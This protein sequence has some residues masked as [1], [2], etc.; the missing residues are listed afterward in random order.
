MAKLT[1]RS[2]FVFWSPLALTWLMIG[3][4]APFLAAIVARLPNPRPNLAAWGIAVAIAILVEAPVIMI[5]SASTAMATDRVAFVRLRA[6][7]YILC[8]A[9]TFI[10]LAA[11]LSPAMDLLVRRAMTVPDR[12]AALTVHALFILL[13]WPAAIG[14]RRFY[15]G[16]LI[17]DGQ[18]RKVALGT[19][20]RLGS[21]GAT[22]MVLYLGFQIPGAYVGAAA[23]TAGVVMEAL[24][25]RVMA[26]R[27]VR[28]L[29]AVEPVEDPVTYGRIW[30]FYYP[31]ALTSTIY[32]TVQP[33]T[34]FFLGRSRMSLESLAVMPVIGAL[35]FLFRAVGISFMEAAIA[36][37][38]DS[39][40]HNRAI[41]RF[42]VTLAVSA[43]AA[44]GLVAFTPLSGQWFEK[45]S[46]LSRELT[47]FA[48]LPTMILVLIPAASVYFSYQRAV[49][50]KAQRTPPITWS[51]M[52]QVAC[53]VAA[54]FIAVELLDTVGAVAAA[55][56]MVLG[57]VVGNS[58]LL[59]PVARAVSGAGG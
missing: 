6:F 13:P 2:I 7:T 19:V 37:L 25:S 22:A 38:G 18:T 32:L 52:L 16:L 57:S 4:E 58:L 53:T 49:L 43:S 39:F 36:L 54:L 17:R 27:I 50:V 21:M 30:S 23:L 34:S 31:L 5:M 55:G 15:Q 9:I 12:V 46:G 51:T 24:A 42:A 20:I 28:K 59:A 45:V 11:L 1:Q 10:M 14:Y 3:V 47:A 29:A 8:A 48:S 26:L 44:L 40:E 56:A 33:M 41:R 35:V